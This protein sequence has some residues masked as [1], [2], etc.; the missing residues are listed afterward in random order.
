MTKEAKVI[1]TRHG[2]KTDWNPK[3]TPGDLID[4]TMVD[5]APEGIQEALD[6]GK[7]ELSGLPIEA[8]YSAT[9]GFLR[10]R[11]TQDKILEGAGLDINQVYDNQ[12]NRFVTDSAMGISGI[13]INGI[14]GPKFGTEQA[15]LDAYVNSLLSNYF[16]KDVKDPENK[17]N[18]PVMARNASAIYHAL[19]DGIDYM[20]LNLRD[21]QQGLV[22]IVTHCPMIDAFAATFD[23]HLKPIRKEGVYEVKIESPISGHNQGHYMVGSATFGD[24]PQ[25]MLNVK[26]NNIRYKLDDLAY[27]AGMIGYAGAEGLQQRNV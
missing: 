20:D 22:L 4:R 1:I 6:I 16:L 26:G 13:N 24:T 18:L 25:I 27:M 17:A 19:V 11:T 5:L 3:Q 7:R 8:V 23:G 12:R 10:T 15:V 9:S 2:K 21:G 14:K